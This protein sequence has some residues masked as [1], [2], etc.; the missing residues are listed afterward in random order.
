MVSS[1]W[2]TTDHGTWSHPSCSFTVAASR[3]SIA[4]TRQT[5]GTWSPE[6]SGWS[7]LNS[8]TWWGHFHQHSQ[9]LGCSVSRM[10]K[11]SGTPIQGKLGGPV[12]QEGWKVRS[13]TVM[14]HCSYQTSFSLQL[15]ELI[16]AT[17]LGRFYNSSM[18]YA[19]GW[20]VPAP[21]LLIPV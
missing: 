2:Q 10:R 12:Q 7:Q 16:H 8:R 19:F 18:V 15:K 13:G 20:V 5:S 6:P 21:Y 3:C 11:G 14:L 1:L 4:S 9:P 17:E